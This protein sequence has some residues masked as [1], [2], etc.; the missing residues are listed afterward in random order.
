MRARHGLRR[1]DVVLV[2]FPYTD[3]SARKQRPA[4]VVSSDAYHATEP[5]VILAA[6]TS[7]VP[8]RVRATDYRLRDWKAA[9]LLFPSVVKS[10]LV[11]I[12]PALVRYRMGKLSDEDMA[13]V[14][15]ALRNALGL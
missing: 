8:R 6:I 3:L 15:L 13:G 4:V 10:C 12:D 14:D 5:D 7:Q 1:G 2:P 9:G 11:T